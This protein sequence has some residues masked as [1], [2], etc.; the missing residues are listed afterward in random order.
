MAKGFESKSVEDQQHQAEQNAAAKK[1]AALTAEDIQRQREVAELRLQRSHILN[2]TTASPHRRAALQ[3][4]L[5]QIE[6]KLEQLGV[7]GLD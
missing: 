7:T 4:A 6:G 1:K 5:E 2:A 3:A